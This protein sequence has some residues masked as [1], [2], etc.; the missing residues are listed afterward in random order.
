MTAKSPAQQSCCAF[1]GT[2]RCTWRVPPDAHVSVCS[3]VCQDT[4]AV[5]SCDVSLPRLTPWGS[6]LADL[7]V[8]VVGDLSG[9][10]RSSCPL[11]DR[12]AMLLLEQRALHSSAVCSYFDSTNAWVDQV[13]CE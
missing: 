7:T 1:C 12:F 9:L 11:S 4:A 3:G 5:Y 13:L 10:S 8:V 6:V 2:L